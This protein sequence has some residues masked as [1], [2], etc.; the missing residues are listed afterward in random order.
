MKCL[1]LRDNK[2]NVFDRFNG[3]LKNC[4]EYSLEQVCISDEKINGDGS[5]KVCGSRS[6]TRILH[7]FN[8]LISWIPTL[9]F[10]LF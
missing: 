9:Y 10:K 1:Q 7:K 3:K 5:G 4:D 8:I 2:L 6:L